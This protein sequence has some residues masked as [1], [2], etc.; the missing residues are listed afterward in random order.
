MDSSASR[1]ARRLRRDAEA[2]RQ[3]TLQA[4]REVFAERG[5][6]VNLDDIARHAGVGVATSYRL[7]GN[8]QALINELFEERVDA[9]VALA[10]QALTIDDPWEGFVS[11][12]T[13]ALEQLEAD[14]GLREVVFAELGG[15]PLVAQARRKF[16]PA[17]D[18]VMRRA[19]DAGLLRS[20][21]TTTD[22]PLISYM[23]SCVIQHTQ[24]V[25]SEVWRR[26]LTIVL[27]GLHVRP[28]LTD[29]PVVALTTA[30]EEHVA[31]LNASRS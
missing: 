30:E 26:Y 27:D 20:D 15:R 3:R 4:A 31:S 8:K 14:R 9:L 29:M 23:V 18:A 2:N 19:Q 7:F 28:G 13:M 21:L 24:P 22:L 16:M 25:S 1:G 12:L 11:L 6:G 5:L 17:A 10:D